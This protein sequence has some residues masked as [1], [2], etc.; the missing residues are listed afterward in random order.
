MDLPETGKTTMLAYSVN[1]LRYRCSSI[2]VLSSSKNTI[3]EDFYYLFQSR[4]LLSGLDLLLVLVDK[5]ELITF[6]AE[7]LIEWMEMC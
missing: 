7:N 5:V 1:Y 6:G 2:H 4:Y 3:Y